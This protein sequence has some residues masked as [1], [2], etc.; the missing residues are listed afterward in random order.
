MIEVHRVTKRYKETLAVDDLS[1]EVRPGQVTGFLGPNGSG[2][3][4]TMRMIMGLDAPDSG[5]ATVNGHRFCDLLL[6][7]RE[8][9]AVLE[10]RSIHPDRSA[11]NHL[12]FLARSNDIPHTRVLEVLELVGLGKV[13]RKR[14]GKFSLGM[15]QRLGIAAAL[16]GDP[17]VLLF[18]E[19]I[20]GLDPE[21]ILWVRNLLKGLAAEG[22]T[23]FVSSHLMS[24]MALTADYLVVIGKGKLISDGSTAEFIAEGSG[25]FVRVR[26]PQSERLEGVLRAKGAV[27]RREA[28][29]ALA[30]SELCAPEIGDLAGTNGIFLHELATQSASLEEAFMEAHA[31]ERGVP[32]RDASGFQCTADCGGCRSHDTRRGT[33]NRAFARGGLMTVALPLSATLPP[34]QGR[35]IRVRS[36][37]A[38]EWIKLRSVRSTGWS[39]FTMTLLTIGVAVIA[40]IAVSHEF[41]TSSLFDKLAFDPTA[42]S[43]RGL[44]FSQL[45]I[46]VLGV[47]VIS[48]EYGTFTI[49]ATLSAVPHRPMVLAAKAVVFGT[50]S[51][52]VGELLSFSAFFLG[53][54]LLSSP[55]PHASLSQPGA[56]RAVVGG[57][58]LIPVFGLFALGLGAIVRH[59]AGA[60][61]AYVGAVLVL[62]LIVEALPSSIGHPVLKFM[63][64]TITN[65][66]TTVRHASDFGPTFSPWVGFAVMCA[67]A[68]P[69]LVIGGWLMVH[70]DV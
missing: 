69:S 51:V 39:I 12:W 31:R 37:L 54:A 23:V 66:M 53:Q 29:G 44:L 16:L 10:A 5:T 42:T 36:V 40:G 27:V 7:L 19:P 61:T 30:V 34:A 55:A 47:L 1:F 11:F 45:V 33:G 38:A 35:R 60:I 9:G 57:G 3:S 28:D 58:L 17:P 50:V 4:T 70:R 52:I 49:R 25:R 20:N 13:A 48:A 63:P 18:D 43:L 59:T 67:Y 6:P 68:A 32:W 65:A 26:S 64:F 46:G 24:E 2:K 21:G 56:S 15:G 22:R 8:V 62:P 41:S 14:A